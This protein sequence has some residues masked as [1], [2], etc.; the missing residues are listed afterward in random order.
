MTS[1]GTY[2]FGLNAL[3]VIEEAFERCGR[4]PASLT[5]RHLRSA[6]RSLNLLSIEIENSVDLP[7]RID[8]VQQT[9][10]VGDRGLWLPAGTMDVLSAYLR[11]VSNSEVILPLRRVSVEDWELLVPKDQGGPPTQYAVSKSLPGESSLVDSGDTA[12]AAG[13]W[14]SSTT[15]GVDAHPTH[16]L[17]LVWWPSA[18]AADT[19]LYHRLRSAQ[20]YTNLSDS[21][22]YARNWLDAIS[23]G[24][25][26]R[27]AMKWAPDRKESLGVDWARAQ[28]LAKQGGRDRSDVMIYGRGFGH[29]ARRRRA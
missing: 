19:L 27:L 7:F 1:T 4:D 29:K 2:D 21:P 14:G 26:Y 17:A 11:L 8:R 10:A 9:L 20:D 5:H 12:G 23:A 16:R 18:N 15:Q 13:A 3:D 24:L 28:V 6:V 22:D 25:A